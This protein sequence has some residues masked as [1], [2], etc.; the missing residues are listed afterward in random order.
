M[1]L[2]I[3]IDFLPVGSAS[4]SGDAIAIRYGTPEN[5]EVMVVDGGDL[6]AGD[7]LVH[8]IKTVYG[9]HH[10]IKHVVC[11]HCDADHVSGLRRLFEHFQIE[12]LW[13]HQPWLYAA[14]LN[15]YF[16]GNWT[17]ANL[18]KHLRNDCFPIVAEVCDLAAEH[19]TRLWEP[20]AGLEIGLFRV[21]APTR[22][23]LLELYPEMDHTPLQKIFEEVAKLSR[24]A[25]EAI[26]NVFETME[27]ET[28]QD[29]G[30]KGTSIANETSV[31]LYCPH[32]GGVLLTGDAGVGAL[33]EALWA[34]GELGINLT[35]PALI[36]IPHHGSRHNVS[37][38]L[39]DALL[40]PK[41][42][43]YI[44]RGLAYASAAKLSSMPRKQVENAF[45]RRGYGCYS[46]KGNARV[47]FQNWPKRA[48]WSYGNP[49]S[50]F[51]NFVEE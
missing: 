25:K 32:F 34:A 45:T 41:Q 49:P 9:E 13:V 50:P 42:E 26:L 31:C 51:H 22:E 5:F 21:L 36:Q 4:K 48:G 2:G 7:R 10:F 14:E 27:H 47:W 11:T 3:E 18:A 23:R 44:H 39:L 30:P 40:G 24:R 16:K 38:A 33:S 46:T 1:S 35:S 37:P 20:L 17:D 8:H 6:A 28:L 19:G 15:P 43:T 29:P 12:N